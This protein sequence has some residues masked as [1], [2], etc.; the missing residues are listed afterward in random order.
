MIKFKNTMNPEQAKEFADFLH[1][2]DCSELFYLLGLLEGGAVPYE[3][4]FLY[5]GVHIGYPVL[6]RDFVVCS[7]VLHKYSYGH[8][9]GL[10][11]IMGL[12]TEEEKKHDG[13]VGSLHAYDAYT[14]LREDWTHGRAKWYE[15]RVR[16]LES[17]G[18]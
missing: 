12:L 4:E 5:G 1:N 14:R 7:V 2:T 13:V 15:D 9:D 17:K 8:E 6:D 10:F 11:E 18:E 3:I 16:S